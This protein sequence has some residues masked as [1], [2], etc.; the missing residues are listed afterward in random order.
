MLQQKSGKGNKMDDIHAQYRWNVK[1]AQMLNV[2]KELGLYQS[3][4]EMLREQ[5]SAEMVTEIVEILERS[6]GKL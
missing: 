2:A 6:Y 4:L 1:A 5:C 3:A